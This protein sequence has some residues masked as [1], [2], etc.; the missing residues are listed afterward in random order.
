MRRA[1]NGPVCFLQ[2]DSS[3]AP[4]EMKLMDSAASTALSNT[5]GVCGHDDEERKSRILSASDVMGQTTQPLLMAD[6][7]S[8]IYDHA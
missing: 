3:L 1:G 5:A 6:Q 8:T 7:I 2:A 4:L